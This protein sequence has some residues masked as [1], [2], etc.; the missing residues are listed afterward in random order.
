MVT[1]CEVKRPGVGREFDLG[2]NRI[3][4]EYAL[5]CHTA[6]IEDGDKPMTELLDILQL[7][8]IAA[9]RFCDEPPRWVPVLC[10][11]IDQMTQRPVCHWRLEVKS[12]PSGMSSDRPE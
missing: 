10:W 12:R 5:L 9:S 3:T 2:V 6:V 11:T 8:Q 7:R 4:V 1:G